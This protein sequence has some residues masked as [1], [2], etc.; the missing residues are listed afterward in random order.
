MWCY[1]RINL[2]RGLS[3]L[4]CPQIVQRVTGGVSKAKRSGASRDCERTRS[5]IEQSDRMIPVRQ[6]FDPDIAIALLR[7]TRPLHAEA[8]LVY[9]DHLAVRQHGLRCR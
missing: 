8:I 2:P 6:R 1:S 9:S 7:N 5:A 4:V 3:A